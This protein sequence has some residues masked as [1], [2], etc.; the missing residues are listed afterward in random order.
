MDFTSKTNKELTNLAEELEIEVESKKK[1]PTKDELVTALEL[2]E[3]E[4]G[5]Q[6]LVD[7]AAEELGL[8]DEE[9]TSEEEEEETPAPKK[10]AKVSGTVYT[11][12]GKG[13]SSPQR[14][15]F[16][17]RQE[18]VRGR[19]VEVTDE[20]VLAKIENNPTFIKGEADAE[21]I[22]AI[23]DEGHAVAEANRK[24]DNQMDENFKKQHGGK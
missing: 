5:N 18:F 23:D 9:E 20:L 1:K 15:N 10:K 4:E 11:Y 21:L 19:A 22:Q 7:L 24:I 14:I 3:Q 13:E 12:V 2:F 8:T 17:G 6:E 16:I